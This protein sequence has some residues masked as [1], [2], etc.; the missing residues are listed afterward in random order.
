MIIL[1]P[2]PDSDQGATLRPDGYRQRDLAASASAWT[3]V[4]KRGVLAEL[5]GGLIRKI[6]ADAAVTATL[7][8]ARAA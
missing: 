5:R 2:P 3:A 8:A 4:R 1:R 7:R 6:V